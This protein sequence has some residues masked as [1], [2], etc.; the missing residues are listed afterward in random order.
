MK[1]YIE[2]PIIYVVVVVILYFIGR[3]TWGEASLFV[4]L[5]LGLFFAIAGYAGY[6]G[7][8]KEQ[9]MKSASED[10]KDKMME[11]ERKTNRVLIWVI[12]GLIIFCIVLFGIMMLI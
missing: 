7:A 2:F 3:N 5:I 4:S 12:I 1:W 11:K 9:K 10:E 6:K 8:K